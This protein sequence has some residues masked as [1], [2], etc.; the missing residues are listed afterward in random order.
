MHGGRVGARGELCDSPGR[1]SPTRKQA[2]PL[3]A[4]SQSHY[5]F[6]IVEGT[7][8]THGWLAGLDREITR[9]PGAAGQ[10]LLRIC[11]QETAG[12]AENNT[13][14]TWQYQRNGGGWNNITT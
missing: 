3:M 12:V 2:G 10:F 14:L 4:L 13:A 11:V 8:S 6:G 5:R 1:I 7:E 9:L